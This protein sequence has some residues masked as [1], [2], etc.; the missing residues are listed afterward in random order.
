M[1]KLPRGR[2]SAQTI[3]GVIRA[4]GQLR[5]AITIDYEYPD[6]EETRTYKLHPYSYRDGGRKFF[7]FDATAKSIKAFDTTRII[8]AEQSSERFIPKWPVEF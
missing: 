2:M 4:A 1:S 5:R 7:G 6:G 3:D 8:R